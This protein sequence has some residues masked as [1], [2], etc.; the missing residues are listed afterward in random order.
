[1]TSDKNKLLKPLL[2]ETLYL[3]S[4]RKISYSSSVAV[5]MR[6]DNDLMTAFNEALRQLIHVALYP[7]HIGVEEIGHHTVGTTKVNVEI[8]G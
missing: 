6:Y 7:A 3:Q 1:M 4:I 5:S 8:H 2:S